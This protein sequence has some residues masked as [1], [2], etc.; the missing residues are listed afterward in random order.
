MHPASASLTLETGGATTEIASISPESGAL[1][2]IQPLLRLPLKQGDETVGTLILGPRS[3]GNRYGR[4]E[5]EI[6]DQIA[7]RLAG[8]L[9]TS[10]IRFDRETGMQQTI[11]A[12]AARIAQLEYCARP[13][14]A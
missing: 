5:R 4:K 2:P 3:D 14:P 10:A 7:E 12:M 13:K 6:L 8:A 11:E 1:S 9:R